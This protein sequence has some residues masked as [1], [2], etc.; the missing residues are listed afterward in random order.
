MESKIQLKEST[1]LLDMLNFVK[2]SEVTLIDSRHLK[3]GITFNHHF[4]RS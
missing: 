2:F 4:Y 1:C 3:L